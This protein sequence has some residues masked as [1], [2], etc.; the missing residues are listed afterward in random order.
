MALQWKRKAYQK[1]FLLKCE[2]GVK[3]GFFDKLKAGLKKTKDNFLGKI[4]TILAGFGKIY[5]SRFRYQHNY[6]DP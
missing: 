1:L 3:M 6:S 5:H 4:D 2:K